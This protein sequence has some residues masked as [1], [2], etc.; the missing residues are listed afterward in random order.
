MVS[1]TATPVQIDLP[2]GAFPAIMRGLR[3][4][5]PRCGEGAL[6]RAWIKPIDNC[7]HCAHDWSV[8]Q[9]DDFPAYIGI[10]VTG[11]LLAPVVIALISTFGLSAMATLAIILPIA[12]VMTL[13][14][15][16][17]VKGGV[18]ALLWWWGVG[19]FKQERRPACETPK[20][21]L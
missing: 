15:L 16:H 17:P 10:F 9:A 11:H 3:A 6:F 2:T 12:I 7:S 1:P 19:A 14:M 8:Q 21:E 18:I 13:A 5:C 20:D 4:K